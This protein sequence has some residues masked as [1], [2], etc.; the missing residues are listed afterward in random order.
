[1]DEELFS[2]WDTEEGDKKEASQR[3]FKKAIEQKSREFT[4]TIG[5]YLTKYRYCDTCE[6]FHLESINEN[7]S[8]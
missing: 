5:S 6:A 2:S 8:T 1:M 7:Q 4:W 3:A